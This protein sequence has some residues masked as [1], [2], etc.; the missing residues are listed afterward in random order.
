[1]VALVIG[2]VEY[3]RILVIG[4]WH[5][6]VT[7]TRQHKALAHGQPVAALIARISIAQLVSAEWHEGGGEA[8]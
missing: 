5:R 3:G 4:Q 6:I 2:P 8:W 7:T 1:M